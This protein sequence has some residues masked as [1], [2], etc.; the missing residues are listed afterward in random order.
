LDASIC[1]AFGLRFAQDVDEYELKI[2]NKIPKAQNKALSCI[3]NNLKPF[4]Y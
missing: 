2:K 4:P 3:T 1:L